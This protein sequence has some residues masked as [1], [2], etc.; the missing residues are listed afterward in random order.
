MRNTGCAR[1]RRVSRDRFEA[2]HCW[3]ALGLWSYVGRRGDGETGRRGD[4]ETGRRGDGETGLGRRDPESLESRP[5]EA[6]GAW[7]GVPPL[8]I[9]VPT[10]EDRPPAEDGERGKLRDEETMK[11]TRHNDLDVFKRA[12]ELAMRI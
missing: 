5:S 1:G 7:N 4:G 9:C 8:G 11:I 10:N 3:S 2:L 12:F 6:A